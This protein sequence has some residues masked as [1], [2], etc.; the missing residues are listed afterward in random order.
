MRAYRATRNLWYVEIDKRQIPLGTHPD[1]LPAPK[2]SKTSEGR[3]GEWNPP[4]EILRAY[5]RVMTDHGQGDAVPAAVASQSPPV[6]EV[7]D[8]FLGWLKNQPDK[9]ERTVSWYEKYLQSFLESLPDQGVL[10][11]ARTPKHVRE[12]LS[13]HPDWRGR[14]A[15]PSSRCSAPSTGPPSRG[16]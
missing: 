15:V 11:D 12:W 9:A 16:L 7:L 10:S 14:S 13:L 3:R 6:T 5:S 4:E 1:G 2:K 8:E